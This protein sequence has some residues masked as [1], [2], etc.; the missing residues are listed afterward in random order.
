M[1]R[2][3]IRVLC[4]GALLL[5]LSSCSGLAESWHR[6]QQRA[7]YVKWLDARF[8]PATVTCKTDC[9]LNTCTQ[10]CY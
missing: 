8:P 5:T 9:F 3:V 6:E 2:I 10:R 7:Q 1:L 4:L